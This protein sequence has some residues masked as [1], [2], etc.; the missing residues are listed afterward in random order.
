MGIKRNSTF[1]HKVVIFFN[2]K[3]NDKAIQEIYHEQG[4]TKLNIKWNF[5]LSKPFCSQSQSGYEV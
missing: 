5:L 4:T 1:T 2:K 3:K